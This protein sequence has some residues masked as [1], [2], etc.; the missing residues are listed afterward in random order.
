MFQT[1]D[2]ITIDKHIRYVLKPPTRLAHRCPMLPRGYVLKRCILEP[3]R[4]EEADKKRC[5]HLRSCRPPVYGS[6]DS[7]ASRFPKVGQ[8]RKEIPRRFTQNQRTYPLAIKHG[9]TN[10]PFSSRILPFECSSLGI[11]PAMELMTRKDPREN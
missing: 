6:A 3:Q 4:S 7:H 8:M 1:T 11:F 2:Q 10:P 5:D 9:W